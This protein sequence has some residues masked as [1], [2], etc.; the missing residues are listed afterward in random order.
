[1]AVKF[2]RYN[3]AAFYPDLRE[4]NELTFGLQKQRKEANK[5]SKTFKR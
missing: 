4:L 3:L 1:M 2:T 5:N